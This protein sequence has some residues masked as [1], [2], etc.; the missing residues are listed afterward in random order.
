MTTVADFLE[1]TRPQYLKQV[2]TA[3]LIEKDA[4][5]LGDIYNR[6]KSVVNTVRT[7]W[8]VGAPVVKKVVGD[9]VQEFADKH[10]EKAKPIVE[11]MVKYAPEKMKEITGKNY[12]TGA[13][14]EGQNRFVYLAQKMMGGDAKSNPYLE[15]FANQGKSYSD[16]QFMYDLS[17]IMKSNPKVA[18][19]MMKNI[20]A[21]DTTYADMIYGM[22]KSMEESD[23]KAAQQYYQNAK[24]LYE[25]NGQLGKSF[26]GPS[27]AGGFLYSGHTGGVDANIKAQEAKG[28]AAPVVQL[29]K[30]QAQRANFG[31]YADT[32]N[33]NIY[34]PEVADKYYEQNF[35]GTLNS[36][37][38]QGAMRYAAPWLTYGVPVA[39]LMSLM[40]NHSAW[41]PVLGGGLASAAYGGA[42]GGG[43]L[44]Q[45]QTIDN[46]VSWMNTP[47]ARGAQN[48]QM[49]A[50][51]ANT[52]TGPMQIAKPNNAANNSTGGTAGT[53]L[54]GTGMSSM[55]SMGTGS[56]G[57][58]GPEVYTQN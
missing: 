48:F 36:P 37:M 17:E 33:S 41:L 53:N 30:D 16:Q 47:L 22:G 18:D 52:F 25:Q 21:G 5:F 24:K 58:N 45:N 49:T 51:M 8:Q 42:V 55:G 46:F 35:Y 40:G 56:S 44:P 28:Y 34:K 29:Y 14:P 12:Y 9:K 7:G 27:M 43:Y 6:G 38:A 15:Y 31:R 1:Q 50:P 23:P 54:T 2:R 39:G 19:V 11:T 20:M 26:F 57:D 32:Y 10:P 3:Y 4:G 13:I